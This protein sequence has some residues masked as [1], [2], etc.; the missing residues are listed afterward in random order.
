MSNAPTYMAASDTEPAWK[1]KP[2]TQEQADQIKG[3]MAERHITPAMLFRE[4]PAR[5]KDYTDG[6]KVINWLFNVPLPK[7][8]P[9]PSPQVANLNEVQANWGHKNKSGKNMP[10]YFAVE[11]DGKPHFFR[12]KPGY[13]AGIWFVEEQASDDYYPVRQ[14][15]R[16]GAILGLIFKDV[17]KARA[18]YG[19]LISRCS[20]CNRTLT[21]HDN[22]Y[23]PMYGPECGGK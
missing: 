22:P 1:P 10:Q 11:M 5:P 21:D 18:L 9:T 23:F 4:F 14:G 13:K 19:Q 7:A 15:A 2:Y 16:R 8:S 20:R 12:V 6:V 3:L 17:D